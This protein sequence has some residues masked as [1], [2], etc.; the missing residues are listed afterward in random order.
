MVDPAGL[1]NQ[2]H[3]MPMSSLSAS[4][5]SFRPY[6]RRAGNAMSHTDPFQCERHPLCNA[7]TEDVRPVENH[8]GRICA[9]HGVTADFA[10]QFVVSQ[11][12]KCIRF[13]VCGKPFPFPFPFRCGLV[14][15]VAAME[16]Q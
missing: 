1:F 15:V 11:L 10:V 8:P 9:L 4:S 16:G 3:D 2:L 7:V 6:S 12:G 5:D 14:I 13:S